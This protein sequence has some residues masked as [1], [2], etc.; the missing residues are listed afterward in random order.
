[1][2]HL[3]QII[4]IVFLFEMIFYTVG[5]A[6]V[7]DKREM[8][9]LNQYS[10]QNEEKYLNLLVDINK[11]TSNGAQYQN[12]Y[13]RHL[14][15]LAGDIV[16]NKKLT[17]A[18]GSIGFYFDKKSDEK[19][20]LYLGL[21]IDAGE[22]NNQEYSTMAIMLMKKNLKDVINTVNSCKS[23]FFENDI[24][25]MVVGWKWVNRGTTEQVNIWIQ[26]DDVIKYEG[27]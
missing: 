14:I 16:D 10:K 24:V 23:I 13:H 18:Q 15:G 4:T 7:N 26:K 12:K 22:N 19:N 8:E 25:G 6:A 20:K 1:M 5:C 27:V 21:D 2:Y 11:Y 17:V 9:I 3:K